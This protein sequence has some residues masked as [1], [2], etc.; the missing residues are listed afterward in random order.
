MFG[1]VL[2]KSEDRIR[3]DHH[4]FF[5]IRVLNCLAAPNSSSTLATVFRKHELEKRRAYEERIREVEHCF[6]YYF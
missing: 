6:F 2:L 5:D 3:E 4:T 1:H